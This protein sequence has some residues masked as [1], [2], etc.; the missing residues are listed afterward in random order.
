VTDRVGFAPQAESYTGR[1]LFRTARGA[2]MLGGR[3]YTV[4]NA[5]QGTAADTAL[6]NSTVDPSIAAARTRAESQVVAQQLSPGGLL[7]F[8]QRAQIPVVRNTGPLADAALPG[9][10]PG[11]L[12]F[13]LRWTGNADLNFIVD[14]QAGNQNQILLSGFKPNEIL[15]PGFGLNTSASGGLIPFDNRGGPK[16]GTEIAYWKNSFPTG[17]FGV[18]VLHASGG[19][20]DFRINAWLGGKPLPIFAFD[21]EGNVV[22]VNTF[23]GTLG[24]GDADGALTFVPRNSILEEN[25]PSGDDSVT[26]AARRAV[27]AVEKRRTQSQKTNVAAKPTV[28]MATHVA[29][30]ADVKPAI[31]KGLKPAKLNATPRPR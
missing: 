1:A 28:A 30:P 12:A 5:A 18:G 19:S 8:D 15:F 23:R 2:T 16:G 27:A 14:N 31:A 13:S 20:A 3:G 17:V 6:A 29:K 21:E 4:A 26:S 25:T 22:K 9:A 11:Q 10:I 7:G 24:K